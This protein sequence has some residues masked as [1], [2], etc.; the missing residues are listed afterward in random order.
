MFR[1]LIEP[2][3]QTVTQE[4]K[5]TK[6]AS[7]YW[8]I[9]VNGVHIP[10]RSGL[11]I[12]KDDCI[13]ACRSTGC[14]S[15]MLSGDKKRFHIYLN[16]AG[17][18][19]VSGHD[20]TESQ[21]LMKLKPQLPSML[22]ELADKLL[23]DKLLPERPSGATDLCSGASPTERTCSVIYHFN[24]EV[25]ETVAVTTKTPSRLHFQCGVAS[26]KSVHGCAGNL[27]VWMHPDGTG[28]T[29]YSKSQQIF[30]FRQGGCLEQGVDEMRAE[31]SDET[32]RAAFKDLANKLLALDKTPAEAE[33]WTAVTKTELQ[34]VAQ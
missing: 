4:E 15:V 10:P 24:D 7:F 34:L 25:R 28:G 11:T 13:L 20:A 22:L 8:E 12:E 5:L 30:Y 1:F 18:V 17:Y 9:S 2:E 3:Q 26:N 23:A 33:V 31:H 21:W 16:K 32:I 19:N 14:N 6:C 27:S 29:G